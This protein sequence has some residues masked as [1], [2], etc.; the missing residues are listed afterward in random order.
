MAR[1]TGG[2]PDKGTDADS[3]GPP[4]WVRICADWFDLTRP[5][6]ATYPGRSA[7]VGQVQ[8]TLIKPNKPRVCG[9]EFDMGTQCTMHMLACVW[10]HVCVVFSP[11]AGETFLGILFKGRV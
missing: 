7:P 9:G 5:W 8:D 4:S 2:A 3:A 1:L 6:S 10:H 11:D